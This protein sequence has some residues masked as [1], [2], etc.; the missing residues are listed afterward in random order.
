MNSS[1]AQ[2]SLLLTSRAAR[3]EVSALSAMANAVAVSAMIIKW[4]KTVP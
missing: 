2:F 1:K 4:A 3:L